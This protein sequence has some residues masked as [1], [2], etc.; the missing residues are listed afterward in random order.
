MGPHVGLLDPVK[1]LLNGQS[2][3]GNDRIP[4]WAAGSSKGAEGPEHEV[5]RCWFCSATELIGK[6]SVRSKGP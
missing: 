5:S 4:C 6:G 3:E 2:A 1:S